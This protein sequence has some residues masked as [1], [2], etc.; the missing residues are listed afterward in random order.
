MGRRMA[1]LG[2]SFVTLHLRRGEVKGECDTRLDTVVRYVNCSRTGGLPLVV[3]T[4]ERDTEYLHALF[5]EL[6][7][8]MSDS[9]VYHGDALLDPLVAT[10]RDNFLAYTV[11]GA[12]QHQAAGWLVKRHKQQE[13]WC[14]PCDDAF[15]NRQRQNP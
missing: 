1:L 4:D 6:S 11:A 10:Y 13:G 3:F 5:V 7:A 14:N 2:R 15:S 8:V 9:P 12:V